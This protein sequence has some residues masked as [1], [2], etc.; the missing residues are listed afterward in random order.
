LVGSEGTLGF[1]GE[2]TLHLLPAP[3]DIQTAWITLDAPATAGRAAAAIFGAGILP[4]IMEL[5][6]GE[7]MRLVRPVSDFR[8]PE[9]GAALLV[10]VDGDE[11]ETLAK[12]TRLCEVAVESGAADAIIATRERDRIAMRRARQLVSSRMKEAYPAKISDDVA[13]PRSRMV[14]LLQRAEE[15]AAAAGFPFS[16]YGHLGD[17]NLHLN[18]LCDSADRDAAQATRREIL[19]LVVAMQGTISGEH[20]LGLAK[21]D[22]LPLEQGPALIELQQKIKALLDPKGILNPGKLLPARTRKT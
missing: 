3:R 5:V 7:A 9:G 13:V 16:A 11:Q 12:L 22:L 21:R 20:G 18:L 4:R 10:E 15:L 14:E 17:G 8:I 6:D 2:A 1:I 19:A